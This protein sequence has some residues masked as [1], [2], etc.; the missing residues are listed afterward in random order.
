MSED[1]YLFIMYHIM[2]FFFAMDIYRFFQH[3]KQTTW[4]LLS[5]WSES[6]KR[7]T[8]VLLINLH[9]LVKFSYIPRF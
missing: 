9:S 4:L 6:E 1:V 2:I 5:L 3:V 7:E 8:F